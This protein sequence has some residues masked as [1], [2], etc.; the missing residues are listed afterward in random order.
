MLVES[1]LTPAA[2]LAAATRNNA[3]ALRMSD[4]LGA[5]APGKLADLV[6]LTAN[7]LDDI[8]NTRQIEWV[9]RG[10]KRVAPRDLLP[11]VPTD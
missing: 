2:A 11:L 4:R 5:V 6:L 8:R 10:G 1:G 9:I 3:A 7:P